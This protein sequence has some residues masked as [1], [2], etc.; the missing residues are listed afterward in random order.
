MNRQK[1]YVRINQ[2]QVQESLQMLNFNKIWNFLI[3][4]KKS[5]KEC[6]KIALSFMIYNLLK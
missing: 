3:P 1:N 4:E 5:I 6:M 2:F